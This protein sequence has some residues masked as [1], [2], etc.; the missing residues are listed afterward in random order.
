[1]TLLPRQDLKN[2][3][4]S[5]WARVPELGTAADSWLRPP[6]RRRET[7]EATFWFPAMDLSESDGEFLITAELPGV[8]ADDVEIDVEDGILTVKGE[9]RGE[10]REE[11]KDFRL[12]EREYG[13]FRRSL[14]LPRSAD[15]ERASADFENGVLTIH[16]PKRKEAMGRKIEIEKN[17]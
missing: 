11:A 14:A 15:P 2:E 7:T 1:M 6:L 3:I 8:K 9:K 17:D 13:A 5:T 10:R 16:L 4:L 12:Y